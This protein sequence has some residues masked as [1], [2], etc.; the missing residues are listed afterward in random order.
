VKANLL[1]YYRKLFEEQRRAPKICK[2]CAV[3][4]TTPR[5]VFCEPCV[6]QGRD[7]ETYKG[8]YRGLY[9][10]PRIR[11]VKSCPRCASEFTPH[12]NAQRFCTRAC[13]ARADSERRSAL[14]GKPCQH[15]GRVIEGRPRRYCNVACRRRGYILTSAKALDAAP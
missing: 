14:R 9:R 2:V 4:L 3:P 7:R 12:H 1:D 13:G 6:E 5:R 11:Q 8:L 10:K 15:C